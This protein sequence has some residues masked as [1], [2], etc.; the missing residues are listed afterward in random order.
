MILPAKR[1]NGY[2]NSANGGI[3]SQVL[4][5]QFFTFLPAFKRIEKILSFH[6]YIPQ[7]SINR[8]GGTTALTDFTFAAATGFNGFIFNLKRLIREH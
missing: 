2:A 4:L 7:F 5:P 1:A 3:H 6:R 8:M